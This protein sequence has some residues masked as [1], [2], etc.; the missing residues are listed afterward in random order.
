MTPLK[1]MTAE[2]IL[3]WDYVKIDDTEG[4]VTSVKNGMV[5]VYVTIG[6]VTIPVSHNKQVTLMTNG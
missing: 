6:G 4:L 5:N 3:P 2:E 1:E